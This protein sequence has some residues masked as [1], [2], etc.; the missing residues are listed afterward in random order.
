MFIPWTQ[1]KLEDIH[2]LRTDLKQDP[3]GIATAGGGFG[4]QTDTTLSYNVWR[5]L[6]I[7]AG[8]QYWDIGSG[9]GTIIIRGL[10][11]DFRQLF[12][13]ATSKRWGAIIGTN[14]DF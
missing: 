9:D 2:H 5:G 3:S 12:N 13:G 14:Y 1:F 4:V 8:F 11:T 7:E 10:T 6:S